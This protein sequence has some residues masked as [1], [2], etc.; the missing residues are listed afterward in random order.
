MKTYDIAK[1]QIVRANEDILTTSLG[2]GNT[3]VDNSEAIQ[4]SGRRSI[5]D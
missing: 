5:W 3:V 1:L 2:V 4:G